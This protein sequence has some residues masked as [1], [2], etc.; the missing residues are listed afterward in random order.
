MS[1]N[2]TS[3]QLEVKDSDK[4]VFKTP[5]FEGPLDLLLWQIQKAEVNILNLPIAEITDQFISYIKEHESSLKNL[6][7]F[8]KMAADLLYIKSRF[9]L[10]EE[11]VVDEEYEDPRQELVDRLLEYQKFKKYTDLL[12]GV[13]TSDSF[14]IPRKENL[15]NVPFTDNDL[16]KGIELSDLF[17]TFQNLLEKVAP[18]KLFN[19]YEEVSI[20]EKRTLL[21]ELLDSGDTVT[22]SD[23]IVDP[24]NPLHIICSFMAILEACKDRMIIFNQPEP[25]GEIY[26]V[27][28]PKD[29]DERLAEEYDKDYDEVVE[30]NLEEADDYSI[31]TQEAKEKEIA[32]GLIEEEEGYKEDLVFGEEEDLLLDEEE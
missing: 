2:E 21:E 14:Y 17:I 13:V 10:P 16:F 7:E 22:I 25:L 27:R 6:A 28:R 11:V 24:T 19:V 23:L 4:Q 5:V 32:E 31:I 29:Y 8:Y 18:N 20:K 15:F 30:H 1:E 12:T 9:L 3:L 26:I